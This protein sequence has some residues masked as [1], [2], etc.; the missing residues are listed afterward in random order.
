MLQ[1][2][3][4]GKIPY[5]TIPPTGREKAAQISA[6]IVQQWSAEFQLDDIKS[7][8]QTAL[9]STSTMDE[10]DSGFVLMVCFNN[11]SGKISHTA[12]DQGYFECRRG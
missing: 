9:A 3:N 10:G 12:L 8:E 5:Y 7:S 4:S 1:D 11:L 6:E 2:W